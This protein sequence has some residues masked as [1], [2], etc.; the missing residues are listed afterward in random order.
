MAI[1]LATEEDIKEI[2]SNRHKKRIGRRPLHVGC[3][4]EGCERKHYARGLC[5]M[6]YMRLNRIERERELAD[7][8]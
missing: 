7:A 3:L 5:R 1:R 8:T 4:I 6:H 2:L